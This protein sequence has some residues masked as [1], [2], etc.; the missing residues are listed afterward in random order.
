MGVRT[1]DGKRALVTGASRGIGRAIAI[2]F[3]AEGAAVAI[4]GRDVT[5]T[6]SVCQE[7]G[8]RGGTATPCP[9]D[10]GD[11]AG[12]ADVVDAAIRG[13]GGLDVVVNNA[14]VI[15]PYERQPHEWEPADFDA[16]LRTNLR[17]PFLVS[18]LA[19]PHLL[20]AGGGVLLHVSSIAA[21]TVWEGE[22]A[23][24]VAKAGLNMFSHHLAVEYAAQGIRS[25]T[26]LPASVAT[27]AHEAALA[28]AP[29]RAVVERDLLARHPVGRF[30]D[31]RE[32][33]SAAVFLCSDQA[34]FL[35]GAEVRIDG[36]YSRR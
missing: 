17:G 4:G 26:L 35:T 33:A 27:E 8:E 20:A 9:G 25:N 5:R 12:A 14:G 1:L 2:A 22:F 18:R 15:A 30:A 31:V 3:A 13:L 10:V 6:C 28:R 11:E 16:V 23:Y 24:G 34:P 36:G 19:I 21:V 29:D 32:I 7:I